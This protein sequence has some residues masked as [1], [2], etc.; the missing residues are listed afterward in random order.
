VIVA[1]QIAVV[2]AS[3]A[4]RALL[5]YAERVGATVASEGAV[6]ICGG[7]GGVMEAACRGAKGAGGLTVGFL[8]GT[9]SAE[10]NQWVDIVV[11]TGM[12]EARNVLVVRSAQAVVAVGGEYG[13]LSE[14]ALALRD[15][16]PVVGIGTWSL[17]RGD[18]QPDSGIVPIDDP[19]EAARTALRLTP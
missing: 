16:I 5:E 10:A 9:D 19:V 15:G 11:P 14:I 7:L 12:G 6:V 18:G 17:T 4:D 8:P 1:V 2:G 13:T 3:R